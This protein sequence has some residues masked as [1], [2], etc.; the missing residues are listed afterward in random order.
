MG[1]INGGGDIEGL[2]PK[3]VTGSRTGIVTGVE[4]DSGTCAVTRS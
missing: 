3:A 4:T 2:G 1:G